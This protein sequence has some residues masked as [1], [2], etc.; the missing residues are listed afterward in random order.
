MPR[1]FPANPFIQSAD[2]QAALRRVLLAFAQHK[3]DVGYCQGLNYVAAL[4]LLAMGRD[5]EKAFWLLASL[6]DD[7]SEGERRR[8]RGVARR[9]G[10][11]A[12]H[13]PC[14]GGGGRG[15]PPCGVGGRHGGCA[16][17]QRVG[18]LW[19]VVARRVRAAQAAGRPQQ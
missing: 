7:E 14:T 4:L 3:Q 2:G 15:Q 10:C 9:G 8:R 6:I 19:A 11:G 1:T 13:V 18:R 17:A 5:E 16:A 12:L